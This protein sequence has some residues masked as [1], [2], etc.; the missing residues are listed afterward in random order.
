MSNAKLNVASKFEY[1][2][3]KPRL[4]LGSSTKASITV[5]LVRGK[6]LV[7]VAQPVV[8]VYRKHVCFVFLNTSYEYCSTTRR[9]L[10]QLKYSQLPRAAEMSLK[11]T[12]V[13]L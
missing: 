8:I 10:W 1:E 9:F 13:C 4:K 11:I 2:L 5:V 3:S 6:V 7:A 12:F